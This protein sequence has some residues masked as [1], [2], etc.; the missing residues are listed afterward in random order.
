MKGAE[1]ERAPPVFLWLAE[2]QIWGETTSW[3]SV[4][5]KKFLKKQLLS[6]GTAQSSLGV[7]LSH[8]WS[9]DIFLC[10]CLMSPR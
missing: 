5:A 3:G 2:M 9:S 4:L 7:V 10:H 8:L 6:A 1:E